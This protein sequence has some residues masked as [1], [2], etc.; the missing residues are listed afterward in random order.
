MIS[1]LATGPAG[2]KFEHV[3]LRIAAQPIKAHP[4][5]GKLKTVIQVMEGSLPVA[6]DPITEAFLTPLD[7]VVYLSQSRREGWEIDAAGVA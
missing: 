4:E 7:L 6:E 1:Y 2:T 3:R 5:Q